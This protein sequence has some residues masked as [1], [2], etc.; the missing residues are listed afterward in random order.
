MSYTEQ[1][2]KLIEELSE[3]FEEGERKEKYRWWTKLW[4]KHT[5]ERLKGIRGFFGITRCTQCGKW[6]RLPDSEMSETRF[7]INR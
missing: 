4:C 5:F 7:T 6:S 3:N 1:D 2:K